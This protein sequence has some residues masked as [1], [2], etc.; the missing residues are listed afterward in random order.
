MQIN[1]Y[2]KELLDLQV[3]LEGVPGDESWP[4]V[5]GDIKRFEDEG[6]RIR[7]YKKAQKDM[8][9][10]KEYV[11]KKHEYT[12]LLKDLKNWNWKIEIAEVAAK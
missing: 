7:E 4:G 12:K 10:V 11:D 8:P 5:L 3:I 9:G 2:K 1:A 6:A